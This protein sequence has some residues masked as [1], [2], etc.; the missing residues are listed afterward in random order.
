MSPYVPATQITPDSP[1]DDIPNHL[2]N[3]DI[4]IFKL[5]VDIVK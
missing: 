5:L 4:L 1:V 3:M 2:G